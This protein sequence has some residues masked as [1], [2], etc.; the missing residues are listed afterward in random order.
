M[1]RDL[2]TNSELYD[3]RYFNDSTSLCSSRKQYSCIWTFS[4][5]VPTTNAKLC[6]CQT[7]ISFSEL[8]LTGD[9]TASLQRATLRI[10][11]SSIRFRTYR[12]Y[13]ASSVSCTDQV[14]NA[15][16]W[17]GL[18]KLIAVGIGL[19]ML[20]KHTSATEVCMFKF[21]ACSLQCFPPEHHFASS[22]PYYIRFIV[23]LASVWLSRNTVTDFWD[24]TGRCTNTC[25]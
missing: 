10:S 22:R 5:K 4:L 6:W 9:S 15:A 13:I 7:G 18:S 1:T 16:L 25:S 14:N 24:D 19:C 12:N 21:H 2:D 11:S 23:S 17:H 3:A 20:R 8:P